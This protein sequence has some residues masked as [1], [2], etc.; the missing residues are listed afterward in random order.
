M[1]GPQYNSSTRRYITLMGALFNHVEVARKDRH[2]KVPVTFANKENFI[3]KLDTINNSSDGDET[4]AKIETI[5]PRMC[6][7]IIDV[8]YN[9]LFK[10]NITNREMMSRPG[11][12]PVTT[13]QFNPVPFKYMFELGI[14][15]RHEDDVF[16]IIEQIL[17]YFQP[18]F[19]C[20]MT[21]LHTNEIKI[22]R[23]IIV[24]LQ[25]IS[26]DES[27]DSDRFSRRRIEWSIIFELDGWMYPPMKDISNE[28]KTIYLDFFANTNELKP[29]GNFESV[30]VS[31]CP[32]PDVS[33][34]EWNGKAKYGYSS[35]MPIPSGDIPSGPRGVVSGCGEDTL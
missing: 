34:D 7:S 25:S 5:L 3:R 26:I 24:T 6:L 8:N 27:A 28:I 29:E 2:I 23:D 30:D 17:P 20:K 14:Y 13:S 19:A 15:A 31:T 1:F 11:V 22:D 16:Q 10:T 21:E 18:H 12:R 33:L 35:D 4:Y 32:D 9:P